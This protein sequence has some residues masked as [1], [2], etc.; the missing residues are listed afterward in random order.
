MVSSVVVGNQNNDIGGF[1]N[2]P[3][4][5]LDLCTGVTL[6]PGA[7]CSVGVRYTVSRTDTR[8]ATPAG[9]GTLT[10]NLSGGTAVTTLRGIPTP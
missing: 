6:A 2:G 9:F 10:F 7:S 5:G 1:S 4:D 8:S 3:N